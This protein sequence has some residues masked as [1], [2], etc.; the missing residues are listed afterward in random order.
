VPEDETYAQAGSCS[1]RTS[2]SCRQLG[3]ILLGFTCLGIGLWFA[4]GTVVDID[5]MNDNHLKRWPPQVITEIVVTIILMSFGP[6]CLL[7]GIRK[8]LTGR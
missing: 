4:T 3:L 7:Q 5:F 8:S 1:G 6:W 2:H